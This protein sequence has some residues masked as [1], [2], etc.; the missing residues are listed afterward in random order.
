[1]SDHTVDEL[2]SVVIYYAAMG[3]SNANDVFGQ[4]SSS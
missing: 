2:L 3:Q 4:S 1:M